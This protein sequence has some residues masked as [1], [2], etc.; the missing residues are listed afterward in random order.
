MKCD[1][2]KHLVSHAHCNDLNCDCPYHRLGTCVSITGMQRQYMC[3]LDEGHAQ[4]HDWLNVEPS[5]G[6]EP[7]MYDYKD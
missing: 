1:Y 6:A 3:K 4:P 7:G 5:R 2:N